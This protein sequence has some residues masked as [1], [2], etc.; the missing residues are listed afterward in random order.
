MILLVGIV[1]G[2]VLG[3][4]GAGGSVFAVPLLVNLLDIPLH[5][6]IGLSLGAVAASAL[7]GALLKIRSGQIQWLPAAVFAALGSLGAPLGNWLSRQ[8]DERY[9]M[10]GFSVLVVIIALR[11]WRQSH[12]QPETADIVRAAPPNSPRETGETLC[13]INQQQKF[14]VGLPCV[15]GMSSAALV[16]GLLSGLFGVGGG[17]LIV[18]SLLILTSMSM[19]PAVATS[20]VVIAIISSAGFASFLLSGKSVE[21]N[22]LAL[23]AAGGIAGMAV[24]V[25][26]SRRIAGA[27]LQKIFAVLMLVVVAFTLRLY[28]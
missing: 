23:L 20:L 1:I 18:P 16:T 6:A 13:T 22:W 25:F 5:Q 11:L 26:T 27:N 17:F 4:T 7:F 2:A 28:I 8:F 19:R 24:G 9:L 15:L 12:A 21:A 10:I 14:R 3:L